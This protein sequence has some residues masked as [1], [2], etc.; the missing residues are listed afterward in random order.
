MEKTYV[1]HRVQLF[2]DHPL[3]VGEAVLLELDPVGVGVIELRQVAE[4]RNNASHLDRTFEDVRNRVPAGFHSSHK[5]VALQ[6]GGDHKNL[7]LLAK[8]QVVAD[9]VRELQDLNIACVS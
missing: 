6:A 3:V 5:D 8:R 4:L 1:E 9:L 2:D 7:E